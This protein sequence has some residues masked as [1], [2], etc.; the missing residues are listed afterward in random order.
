MRTSNNKKIAKPSFR[1]KSPALY[2]KNKQLST[3]TAAAPATKETATVTTTWESDG[4]S[5]N[6]KKIE[7]MVLN[8]IFF[9]LNLLAISN[10]IS[11]S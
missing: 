10:Y 2:H 4:N 1:T 7:E 11:I 9:F 8:G 5:S 6:H 3:R